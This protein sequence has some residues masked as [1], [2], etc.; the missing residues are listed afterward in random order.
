[1]TAAGIDAVEA[2]IFSKINVSGVTTLVP[3]ARHCAG[4]VPREMAYPVI[5]VQL[6]DSNDEGSAFADDAESY[7]YLVKAITRGEYSFAA[8]GEIAEQI[9]IALN[10]ASF[11]VTGF[12]SG[13]YGILRER[14]IRYPEQGDAGEATRPYMHA[15]ALYR[16]WSHRG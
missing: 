9:D 8:V 6:M 2:G 4:I 13:V 7:L 14:R 3:A 15:G 12:D 16:L 1:M 10:R 11:S 5:V